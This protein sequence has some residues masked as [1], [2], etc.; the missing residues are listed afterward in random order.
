M[1][2]LETRDVLKDKRIIDGNLS[3]NFVVHGIDISLQKKEIMK[4]EFE[5][6]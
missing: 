1:A 2:Y 6:F 5:I 3:P 4:L